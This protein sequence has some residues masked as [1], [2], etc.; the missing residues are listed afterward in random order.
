MTDIFQA[1]VNFTLNNVKRLLNYYLT[2]IPFQFILLNAKSELSHFSETL[3]NHQAGVLPFTEKNIMFDTDNT[4]HLNS[5][6]SLVP[7][8]LKNHYFYL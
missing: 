2:L 6:T 3:S 1:F 8:Q 5:V 7:V 4:V